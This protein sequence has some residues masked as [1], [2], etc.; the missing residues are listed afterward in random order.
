M[1][2]VLTGVTG[3]LPNGVRSTGSPFTRRR[4]DSTVRP[5]KGYAGHTK[6]RASGCKVRQAESAPAIWPGTDP[7]IVESIFR[8]I[9]IDT[10]IHQR[11][12]RSGGEFFRG[13]VGE[14]P[15]IGG[16]GDHGSPAE[17]GH[18]PFF[19]SVRLQP[20]LRAQHQECAPAA[21]GKLDR[22]VARAG[23]IIGNDSEHDTS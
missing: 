4:P 10:C 1:S 21:L 23:Q 19:G 13:F 3:S 15:A 16:D 7:R 22:R 17:A 14:R 20:D 18:Y 11:C 6:A 12:Q 9:A 8:K 5:I 2:L